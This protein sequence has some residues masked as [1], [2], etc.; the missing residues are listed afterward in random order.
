MLTIKHQMLAC[1][2]SAIGL[3][4]L[5]SALRV[6]ADD[7]LLPPSSTA[8][9]DQVRSNHGAII[10]GRFLS[11][12]P[13]SRALFISDTP[14]GEPIEILPEDPPPE[15]IFFFRACMTSSAEAAVG[16]T[17]FVLPQA[18]ATDYTLDIGQHTAALAPGGKACGSF[19]V[20]QE[21]RVGNASVAVLWTVST[22]DGDL[23]F[24]EETS[25]FTGDSVNDVI[26]L[27]GEALYFEICATNTSE[28]TATLT[29]DVFHP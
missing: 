6:Y 24:L 9:T 12:Q 18:S 17:L 23:N 11:E 25:S 3:L 8:C 5:G 22:F 10:Y 1:A 13:P 14:D 4:I 21:Q 27:T 19:G 26:T 16:Y 2:F 15:G 28:E 7:G 20:N 29:F